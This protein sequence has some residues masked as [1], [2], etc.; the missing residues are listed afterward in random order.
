[1]NNR[2][3]LLP[4]IFLTAIKTDKFKTGCM[5]VNFLRPLCRQEAAQNALIPDVLLRGSEQHPTIKSISDE[6]DELYGATIGTLLRKKGETQLVGLYAD[7]IEDRLVG[8]PILEKLTQFLFE[9]LLQPS[10][11]DGVF[12]K[13]FVESEKRNLLN[14]IAASVNDK[15]SYAVLRLFSD[16]CRDEAYGVPRLGEQEDAEAITPRSLYAQYQRVLSASRVE[17]FYMGS[18]SAEEMAAL[19]LPYLRKIPRTQPDATPLTVV[20]R[21]ETVRYLSETRDVTQGK[22]AMGFRTDCT[23]SD[24]EYAALL[25]LCTVFG[26]GATS[27]LFLQVREKMSLCYYAGASIEQYKGVMLVSSGIEFE[28]YETARD[29]ILHQLS[30]CCEGVI[31]EEELDQAKRSLISSLTLALDSPGRMD[32]FYIGHAAAELD[33]TVE[34]LREAVERVTVEDTAAAARKITLDTVYFLKG[35]PA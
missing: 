15:R 24:K 8:E 20:R 14:A 32:D 5:S 13:D 31:S 25:T 22:L 26:G 12:R 28:K 9:L 7:F 6:L 16:M 35:E 27:K 34:D 19:L 3:E 18:R 30:L 33:G 11:E 1:M 4:G 23:A 2:I 17:L 10:L 29:E 21:A